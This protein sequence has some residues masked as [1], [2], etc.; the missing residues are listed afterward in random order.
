MK[1]LCIIELLLLIIELDNPVLL[2]FFRQVFKDILFQTAQDK[3]PDHLLKPCLCLLILIFYNRSLKF[4]LERIISIQKARHKIVK[5]APQLTQP[6]LN[7]S[8]C[9]CK[10]CLALYKLNRLR[11]RCSLILDILRFV[12]Y[13]IFKYFS[14]I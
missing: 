2:E 9:Q 4:I 3:R 14:L 7:R 12:N 1:N 10:L 13:L 6:V 11:R 8:S 5:Y